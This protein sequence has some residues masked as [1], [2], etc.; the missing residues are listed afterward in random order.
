M[1]EPLATAD[2]RAD[3]CG[4]TLLLVEDNPG[5]AYLIEDHIACH[6]PEFTTVRARTLGTARSALADGQFAGIL[7]DLGL[8]DTTGLATLERVLDLRPDLPILVVTGLVD[9]EGGIEAI[10]RGAQDFVTK[11]LLGGRFLARALRHA[12][13]RHRVVKKLVQ[14]NQ[15]LAERTRIDAVTGLLTRRAFDEALAREVHRATR[16]GGPFALAMLDLDNFKTINDTYGHP[17][18]DEVLAALGGIA[19]HTLR[20]EDSMGRVGGEEFA[21]LMPQTPLGAA[22]RAV[23]RLV[24]RLN[25]G[26]VRTS[27]GPIRVTLSA[28]V[29]TVDP[30][31]PNDPP[32][33]VAH[34]LAPADRALYAAKAAGRN[35]IFTTRDMDA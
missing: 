29:G 4:G 1:A 28:G 9:D 16:H 17:A 3:P 35:R 19:A 6:A 32:M 34:L 20:Q 25:G 33:D 7:L 5:D 21:L 26:P 31:G 13:E 15:E 11:D 14:Q 24:D 2:D 8:P 23:E 30:P 27:A 10:R 18:G 22:Q 12:L